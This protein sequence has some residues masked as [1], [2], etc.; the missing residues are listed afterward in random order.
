MAERVRQARIQLMLEWIEKHPGVVGRVEGKLR[1]LIGAYGN[2][3]RYLRAN[4]KDQNKLK[5]ALQAARDVFEEKKVTLVSTGRGLRENAKAADFM[6]AVSEKLAKNQGQLG[7]TLQGWGRRMIGVG[8]RIGWFAF[9]TMVLGRMIMNWLL[10]PIKKGIRALLDWE[11]IIDR[12]ATSMGLLAAA[13]LLTGERLDFLKGAISTLI[14]K[15]IAFSGAWGY[16]Q[17]VLATMAADI[18]AVFT[19]ALLEI[20]DALVEVW[21]QVKPTLIPAL[22]DLVERVLPPLLSLIRE[23]GPAFI[24][25]FVDGLSLSVPLI[26]S[27]LNALKPIIPVAATIIGFLAPFAPILVAVGV[28]AYA[29]SP[30]FIALGTALQLAA[31]SAMGVSISLTGLLAAAA[32]IIAI[33]LA[34][35]AVIAVIIVVWQN[36]GKIVKW[37]TDVTRPLHPLFNAIRE[38]LGALVHI[39]TGAGKVIYNL[40]RIMFELIRIA[41]TPLIEKL[42]PVWNILKAIWQLITTSVTP[43]INVLTAAIR[44]ITDKLTALGD[45]LHGVGDFLG[46]VADA[47]AGLCFRHVTPM[48]EKFSKAMETSAEATGELR[49]GLTGLRRGLRGTEFGE[50]GVGGYGGTQNVTVY[51]DINIGTVSSEVDLSAV[52]DAVNRGIASALRRRIGG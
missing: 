29:L 21:E 51:A 47:L 18:A 15:G 27:L 32:P 9:R 11:G 33:I 6:S 10:A 5:K 37:F 22:E 3:T 12:G 30:I 31:F 16:L 4:I 8:Y 48:V 17:T 23:V 39:A 35:V 19:P 49:T 50:V 14:E 38:Y 43:A 13:G 2:V 26:I 7:R 46:G 25:A 40:G 41:L 1:S 36:W 28:A 45:I 24:T 42:Q 52:T 44:V 34:I 20:A